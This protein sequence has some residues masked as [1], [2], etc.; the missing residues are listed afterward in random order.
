KG[1]RGL[2]LGPAGLPG[3]TPFESLIQENQ[4]K[5]DMVGTGETIGHIGDLKIENLT[6]QPISCSIPPTIVES[7][8]GKNQDYVCPKTETVNI[9]PHG[10]ATVPLNGVC[11]NRHKPP[12]GKGAPG[13][14]II[15]SGDPNV[16]H[17]PNSHV[18]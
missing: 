9:D 17:N 4:I 8:S 2:T 5:I 1:H 14:P 13:D 18:P 7:R 15:N 3:G 11:I 6:D 10:T 16:P 12:V